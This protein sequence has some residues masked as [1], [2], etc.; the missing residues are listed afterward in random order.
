MHLNLRSKPL[1]QLTMSFIKRIISFFVNTD[2]ELTVLHLASKT[3][4]S[5]S[6]S[7]WYRIKDKQN[8]QIIN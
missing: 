8:Y 2:T 4:K 6:I 7:E 3:I 5:I 1:N